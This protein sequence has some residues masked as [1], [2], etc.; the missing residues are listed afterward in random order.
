VAWLIP[1]VLCI[2]VKLLTLANGRG[3]RVIARY[4]GRVEGLGF[5]GLNFFERFSLFHSEI[6]YVFLL[7]PLVLLLVLAYSPRW[8]RLP[9][10]GAVSVGP[11]L[12]LF[13]QSRALDEMGDFISLRMVGVA[14]IWGIHDP[15]ANRVYL[16]TPEFYIVLVSLAAIVAMLVWA[17]RRDRLG[18]QNGARAARKWFIAGVIYFSGALVLSVASLYA[19][20]P[21]TPYQR[22]ILA[23]SVE[24]L[25]GSQTVDTRE[26]EGKSISELATTYHEMVNVPAPEIDPAYFGKMRGANLLIFVLE[27]TPWRFLP[28]DG[29]LTDFPTIRQL[30]ENSFVGMQHFTTYPYTN[31]ALFSVF[32][33]CYPTDG[34][35]SF[36][37]EHPRAQIPS[38]ARALSAAGYDTALFM[39][40]ALHGDADISTFHDLGFARYVTPDA[41]TIQQNW[42][43]GFSENW[44]AERIARDRSML[45]IAKNDLQSTLA[46]NRPFAIAMAPQIGHLPWPDQPSPQNENDIQARAHAILVTEDSWLGE[47]TQLLAAHHQLENTVI[48]IF[49]DHGIRTRREDPNFVGTSLDDYSFHVPLF[50]YALRALPRTLPI[51]RLTSHIDIAPTILDLLGIARNRELEQGTPIWNPQIAARTTFFFARQAFGTDGFH[52]SGQF[53]M[54]NQLEDAVSESTAAH[55]TPSNVVTKDS[56]AAKDAPARIRRM[57]AFDQVWMERLSSGPQQKQQPQQEQ[58]QQ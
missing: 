35:R 36:G 32:T 41:A 56:A 17:A 16:F 31:P 29:D 52:A 9:I 2:L 11:S 13:L 40:S 54:W 6:L 53:F 19:S 4:L 45:Q 42:P 21:P 24:A 30:R 34:T 46:A 3:F 39:P 48:V 55:F 43:T 37:E 1:A 22:N 44:K 58:G 10:I 33:S 57:I 25:W 18:N 27:T 15:G 38:L 47:I 23:R 28:G 26:F 14:L 8:L 5:P 7:A 12:V 50:I 51:S 20:L 49:G